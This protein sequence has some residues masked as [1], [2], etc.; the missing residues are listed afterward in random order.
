MQVPRREREEPYQDTLGEDGQQPMTNRRFH[1]SSL[2]G[3]NHCSSNELRLGKNLHS[4]QPRAGYLMHIRRIWR[5]AFETSGGPDKLG[6]L[7]K[8]KFVPT[9]ADSRTLTVARPAVFSI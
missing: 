4:H 8:G 9:T 1:G 2:T 5:F 3:C 6:T 7:K